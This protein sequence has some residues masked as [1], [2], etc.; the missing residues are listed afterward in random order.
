MSAP[1]P[2]H[3][4]ARAAQ[5]DLRF[6]F[7]VDSVT[8]TALFTTDHEGRITSWN[9]GANRML[10]YSEGEIIGQDISR[11][12]TTEDI[13]NSSPEKQRSKAAQAGRTEDDGWRVRKDGSHFWAHAVLTA[14]EVGSQRGFA[15]VMQDYTVRRRRRP[16]IW[17]TQGQE[18]MK[19]AGAVS[20]ARFA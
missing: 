7:L 6:R 4:D 10:G 13:R 18:R 19:P 8:D 20:L 16:S 14:K 9:S 15:V 17:T 3:I 11:L 5:T 12:F 1:E 2:I